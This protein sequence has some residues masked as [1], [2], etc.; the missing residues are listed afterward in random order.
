M[1]SGSL[2]QEHFST[3][4]C[5]RKID[6]SSCDSTEDVLRRWQEHSESALNFLPT[7]DCASLFMQSGE[8]SEDT[9]IQMDPPTLQE[10]RHAIS[11]LKSGRAPGWDNIASEMLRCASEPI[12]RDLYVLFL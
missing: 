10:I 4:T 7:G 5:D 6:G 2:F 9:A 8:C 11:K 12:A 1:P 3:S